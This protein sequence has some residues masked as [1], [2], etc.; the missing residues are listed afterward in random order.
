MKNFS[1]S[2][3][4]SSLYLKLEKRKMDAAELQAKLAEQKQITDFLMRQ[5]TLS[6][7]ARLELMDQLRERDAAVDQEKAVH[8]E[9]K[10]KLRLEMRK[11]SERRERELVRRSH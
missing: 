1:F 10:S 6:E 9:Y 3:E 5:S 8:Q 11:S 7:R 2:Q 4:N